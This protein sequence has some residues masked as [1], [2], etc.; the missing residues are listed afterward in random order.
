MG[1]GVKMVFTSSKAI[2]NDLTLLDKKAPAA[3]RK[4]LRKATGIVLRAARQMA[5]IDTRLLRRSIKSRVYVAKDKSAVLGEVYV[6]HNKTM[7]IRK[8][9]KT[10]SVADPYFYA[11]LVELGTKPHATG[12]DSQLWLQRPDKKGRGGI[13]GRQRGRYH[14]GAKPKPYLRP[15]LEKNK[16]AAMAAIESTL[17]AELQRIWNGR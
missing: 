9:R 1:F 5:P 4:A 7:V 6:D 14:P 10:A 11:H 15:A 12:K 8:S 2:I 17:D 13:P 16:S 3:A